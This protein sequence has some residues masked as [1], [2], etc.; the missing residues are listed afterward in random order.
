MISI[1]FIVKSDKNFPFGRK[2]FPRTQLLE[3]FLGKD[4]IKIE[5]PMQN[6]IIQSLT[7]KCILYIV[8]NEL[9]LHVNN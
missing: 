8:F 1:D 4:E 2:S 5:N 6:A 3:C 7:A 9:D